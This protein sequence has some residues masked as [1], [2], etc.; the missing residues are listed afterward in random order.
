MTIQGNHM[1]SLGVKITR[2]PREISPQASAFRCY[3]NSPENAI[4]QLR[5]EKSYATAYMTPND[6]DAIIKHLTELRAEFSNE[7]AGA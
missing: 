4:I 5:G 1:H 6:I 7:A 3:R 2:Y